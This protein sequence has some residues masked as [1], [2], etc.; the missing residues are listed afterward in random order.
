LTWKRGHY[1]GVHLR[2]TVYIIILQCVKDTSWET[3]SVQL[4]K[5]LLQIFS[6]RVLVQPEQLRKR[7][8]LKQ[9]LIMVVYSLKLEGTLSHQQSTLVSPVA[10]NESGCMDKDAVVNTRLAAEFVVS[11]AA[12]TLRQRAS[13]NIDRRV[14]L[15]RHF[16]RCD[17]QCHTKLDST[18]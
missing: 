3:K 5:N 8:S 10:C 14:T 15:K 13:D 7:W 1:T 18:R 17:N 9:I 16:Q 12:P 4:V 11:Q 6:L 2:Y